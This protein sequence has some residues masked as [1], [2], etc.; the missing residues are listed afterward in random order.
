MANP[1]VPP[2]G[3]FPSNQEIR[4][5]LGGVVGNP[6]ED[7]TSLGVG[8]RRRSYGRSAGRIFN[9]AV[10]NPNTGEYYN[11]TDET[12]G[13]R[14][15][16]QFYNPDQYAYGTATDGD[17][18]N[19]VTGSAPGFVQWDVPTSSTNY[20]RPRTV[21]AG[22]TPDPDDPANGTMTVV[23]RDGTFYNYYQVSPTEW[24]AF[25]AS[26]SKGSPWLNKGYPGGKQTVDG[27]FINK[28]RGIATDDST[29]DPAIRQALYRVATTQQMKQKPKAGRTHQTLYKNGGT[30]EYGLSDSPRGRKRQQLHVPNRV[31]RGPSASK[32]G[33]NP[34]N[35]KRKA[36]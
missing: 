11:K 1:G 26:Y 21:A 17:I 27:L 9:D 16:G 4:N 25:Y 10:Q 34:A 8:D 12:L 6:G 3:R 32:G 31:G 28:P 22:Y 29:M 15:A 33:M 2:G 30:G 7:L 23:F 19:S 36:S 14:N 5:Q 24:Q 20:S 18:S 35:K 13:Y